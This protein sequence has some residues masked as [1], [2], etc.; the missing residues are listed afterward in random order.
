MGKPTALG[1]FGRIAK[2]FAPLAA[3]QPGALDLLDDAALVECP[4]GE[5]L[6]VT[7]DAMVEGV[8]FLSDDPPDLI[9]RKLVR[10]NLSDLAAMAARPVGYFLTTALPK[11]R[12]DD[13][14]AR[15]ADGLAQDQAE[16]GIALLGGDSVSTPGPVSLTLTAFGRVAPGAEVRRSGARPGDLVFVSGTI[17]DGAFG[18]EAARGQ[19][20][21]RLDPA[22]VAYLADRYRLPRPRVALGPRLSGLASAMMDVSDGLAGDL[23][24]ICAA[25]SVAGVIEAARVP[26]SPAAARLGRLELALTGGDDYEL[27]F[28]AS[29]AQ[30]DAILAAA[31]AAGVPVTP[32]GRIEAGQGVQVLDAA[33]QTMA[34]AGVG[35]RHF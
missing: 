13:W 31:A 23:G 2:F 25:S 12:G 33:G 8:H 32:I 7:V 35:W 27:L 9:A 30:Q 14:L 18:L 28:T 17:G 11:S 6:V 3:G 16:F 15:F 26:L 24:H 20:D 4:P 19:L 5:R 22:E 21:E 10:V 34:L 29:R 1:E